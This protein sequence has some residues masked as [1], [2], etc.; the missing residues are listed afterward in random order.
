[1]QTILGANGI[2]ATEL[3]KELYKN[4]TKKIRLVSRNPI[5][6][7]ASDELFTADL[8][9]K[10][11]CYKAVEGSE[12]A[13]ITV[14]LPY[15]S[16]VWK[17]KWPVIMRNVI[18]ACKTHNT[19]LVFFD[20]VYMYGPVIGLMT[21]DTPFNPM[22][23][24]GFVRAEIATLLRNEIENNSLKAMICRAPEFYGPSPT[25]SATNALIF[26]NIK[27]NKKLNVLLND[28]TLRTLIYAPDAGKA[29]ALLG[30]TPDAYGQTWHLPCDSKRK[31]SKEFIAIC[32]E[33]YGKDLN[34]MI[35]KKWMVKLSGVFNSEIKEVVEL[36]YQFDHDYLFDCSKFTTRFPK[37]KINSLE[38][39]ISQIIKEIKGK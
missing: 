39:G 10:K 5:K 6:V 1:M 38:Q 12:I 16:E 34:Y 11:A 22:S 8:L 29:T 31:T 19:K 4:Y 20:N 27:N 24:K 18:D 13:Y 35:L 9:N 26:E 32:S 21:E 37:F 33:K 17:S 14:G 28:E 30:N 36:L 15:N 3:A 2:I 23:K 25:K 7:N